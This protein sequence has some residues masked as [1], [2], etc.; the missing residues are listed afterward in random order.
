LHDKISFVLVVSPFNR[1]SYIIAKMEEIA[2][3]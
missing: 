3:K 2:R 1:G